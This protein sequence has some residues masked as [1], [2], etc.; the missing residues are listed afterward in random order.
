MIYTGT[1]SL[2]YL[3]ISTTTIFKNLTIILIAIGDARMFN[4]Q[5][6]RLMLVSFG[7][8]VFSSFLSGY[9]DFTFNFLGYLWM[10]LNC[11]TSA[12]FVLYMRKTIRKVEFRDFDTVFFN[13]LLAL[14]CMLFLSL[15][16]DKWPEFIT[17][18][19]GDGVHAQDRTSLYFF[20]FVSSI[21]SFFIS[22][23]SA[24]SVRVASSTTYSMVGALNKLPIAVSGIIFLP[25]ERNLSF[26]NLASI[27]IAFSS[28]IVY[29]IAQIRLKRQKAPST[30]KV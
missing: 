16:F 21:S 30:V 6:T 17:A 22:Y 29:S 13:N 1:K 20:I 25:S 8:M 24:W 11:S 9:S 15:M 3:P 12:C 28:G 14:P 5:I 2:Q 27:F 19:Y 26:G 4:G 23:A 18:Y 10:C 7:L